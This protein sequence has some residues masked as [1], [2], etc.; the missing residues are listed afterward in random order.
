[1][2]TQKLTSWR[3]LKPWSRH[4]MILIIAGIT[5]IV[6][7]LAHA[8]IPQSPEHEQVLYFALE[9][10]PYE[11]WGWV[12]IFVGLFTILSARWPAWTRTAGYTALTG[13]SAAWA[14]FYLV[15][16]AHTPERLP[17]FSV[18]MTW[19]MVAFLWWSI[20]GLIDHSKDRW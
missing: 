20:S 2:I 19:A 17:Y 5:Y 8:R 3:L 1:M 16:I 10:M 15:G 14:A 18:A 12:F 4:S 7:G 6:K 13:W 11:K 9:L